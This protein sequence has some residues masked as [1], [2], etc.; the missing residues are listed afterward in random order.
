MEALWNDVWACEV[1]GIYRKM[2]LQKPHRIAPYCVYCK[3]YAERYMQ[4]S[5]KTVDL[6]NND[7]FMVIAKMRI[8]AF[9]GP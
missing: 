9:L 4:E 3:P 6:L 2:T 1:C 7:D 8:T 5:D